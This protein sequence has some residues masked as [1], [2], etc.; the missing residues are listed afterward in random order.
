MIC[1][2]WILWSNLTLYFADQNI[3]ELNNLNQSKMMIND[4]E[5]DKFCTVFAKYIKHTFFL[6]KD[7]KWCAINKDRSVLFSHP[8]SPHTYISR[9][10]WMLMEK[11]FSS[12]VVGKSSI[13]C[14]TLILMHENPL[15]T[16]ILIYQFP[17]WNYGAFWC[18]VNVIR[19]ESLKVQ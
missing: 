8:L 19:T 15:F 16:V 4:R 13:V 7:H 14:K 11:Q 9:I 12:R 10:V 1:D 3:Y 6:L 18:F 5:K 2:L 17:W